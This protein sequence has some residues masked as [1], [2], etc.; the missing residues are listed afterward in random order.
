[1]NEASK[2]N[3]YRPADF[4]RKYLQG[5][6]IDIGASTDPVCAWAEIFDLEQGDANEILRF[7]SAESYDTVHSSH[8][9]E[10]MHDPVAA[11]K[12]WWALVR[13]GGFLVLVV[14]EED[15][16]EQ[17]IWPSRFNPDHKATFRLRR[18]TTWSPVSYDIG[19]MV[20]A[21]PDAGVISATCQAHGYDKR[22]MRKA[23]DVIRSYELIDKI[24]WR[25]QRTGPAGD[26]RAAA[27]R[28]MCWALGVVVD[29]TK[30]GALAQIEV[31]LQKS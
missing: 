18:S 3:K 8:C 13:K 1:M 31:V 9:L 5:K 21:L 4:S 27:F 22:Y 15:M 26:A 19:E 6:V 17:G 16:Y 25:L 30:Y 14:P 12:Q 11:L 24:E 2:T 29:Q 10:H 7:R 28:K 23:G 20:D